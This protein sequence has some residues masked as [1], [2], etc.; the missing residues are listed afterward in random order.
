VICPI[1]RNE[2]QRRNLCCV[3]EISDLRRHIENQS[4]L[5]EKLEDRADRAERKTAT[6]LAE[7]NAGYA[8]LR[9]DSEAWDEEGRERSVLEVA[10]ADGLENE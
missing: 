9:M 10:S 2:Q 4:R 7:L 8:A 3:E 5:I 6:F 1:C